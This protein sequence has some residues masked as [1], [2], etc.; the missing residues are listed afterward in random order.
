MLRPGTAARLL[1][2]AGPRIVNSSLPSVLSSPHTELI[3]AALGG[4]FGLYLFFRGFSQLQ[5]KPAVR[6]VLPATLPTRT[7]VSLPGH[8]TEKEAPSKPAEVIRLSADQP[9]RSST[10]QQGKIAAALQKAGIRNPVAWTTSGDQPESSVL[11]ADVR[12]KSSPPLQA[13]KV[14]VTRKDSPEPKPA[15]QG[16]PAR[17]SATNQSRRFS[18]WMVWIGATIFLVSSYVAAAHFGWL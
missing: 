15:P 8:T 3:I 11:V 13:S 14:N 12:E 17:S 5:R 1:R 16:I 18:V 7:V 6:V 2:G 10:S 4:S 9:S